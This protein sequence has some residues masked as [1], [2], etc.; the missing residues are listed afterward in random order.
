MKNGI[1]KRLLALFLAVLLLATSDTSL[2]QVLA[3]DKPVTEDVSKQEEQRSPVAENVG[4]ENDENKLP[5]AEAKSEEAKENIETNQAA[6]VA[7][8]P[9]NS[10]AN[11]EQLEGEEAAPATEEL[12]DN[13]FA[14]DVKVAEDVNA[15]NPTLTDSI[16]KEAGQAFLYNIGYNYSST[17][18]ATQV[19]TG[20]LAIKFP[21]N[22]IMP[23]ELFDE[24]GKSL[25]YAFGDYVENSY[26]NIKGNVLYV[27]MKPQSTG[28]ASN[29]N[30]IFDTL[31]YTTK[32]GTVIK[33]GSTVT[34]SNN[35]NT[36][37]LAIEPNFIYK[38]EGID[39]TSTVESKPQIEITAKDKW[40]IKKSA[41]DDS[42]RE[43]NGISI[44]NGKEEG[45][46]YLGK[47]KINLDPNYEKIDASGQRRLEN[48]SLV[49][50]IEED[51]LNNGR[52]VNV[53]NVTMNGKPMAEGDYEV[54]TDNGVVKAIKF[55]TYDKLTE[56]GTYSRAGEITRTEYQYE[57]EYEKEGYITDI[58]K[59][60][61]K[62]TL[63]DTADLSY[64][65]IGETTPITSTS[66]A[67]IVVGRYEN[68]VETNHV[69]LNKFIKYD[70]KEM[71]LSTGNAQTFGTGTIKFHLKNPNGT[72]ALDPNTTEAY[73]DLT[74]DSFGNL[75]TPELKIG[76]EYVLEEIVPEGSTVDKAPGKQGDTQTA[77]IHFTV[78]K[79]GETVVIKN[80]NGYSTTVTGTGD[81][82]AIKI[83]NNIKNISGVEFTKTG[84]D[85]NGAE[86]PLAGV[87]FVLRG[88]DGSEYHTTSA[89]DGKVR[90][91][92][93]VPSDSKNP[94]IT[95]NIYEVK[96]DNS[97]PGLEE[98]KEIPLVTM[99]PGGTTTNY[100]AYTPIYENLTVEGGIIKR[101]TWAGK[102]EFL[103]ISNK[104]FFKLIKTDENGNTI[105]SPAGSEG[106]FE[107]YGPL[108]GEDKSTY[109]NSDGSVKDDADEN[110]DNWS[111]TEVKY[112]SDGPSYKPTKALE[113]GIYIIKE[114]KAPFSYSINGKGLSEA[115]VVANTTTEVNLKNSRLQPVRFLKYGSYNEERIDGLEYFNGVKFD[116]YKAAKENPDVTNKND[117]E[118]LE[119]TTAAT[120]AKEED[121]QAV[122]SL[123]TD[124]FSLYL[125][126]GETYYY[127]ET[128]PS[129]DYK[130]KANEEFV[131]FTVEEADPVYTVEVENPSNAGKIEIQK[132]DNKTD[133]PLAGAKYTIYKSNAEGEK[134]DKVVEG[135]TTTADGKIL[136]NLLKAGEDYLIEETKAP[137]GYKLPSPAATKHIKLETNKTTSVT[138]KN[139]KFVTL[140]VIKVD[141][142][143]NALEGATFNYQLEGQKAEPMP[144]RGNEYTLDK[145]VLGEK[146]TLK[147]TAPEGYQGV[148]DFTVEI[149]KNDNSSED[150]LV[151]QVWNEDSQTQE[152]TVT[153]KKN[154]SITISKEHNYNSSEYGP[155]HNENGPATFALYEKDKDGKF[156]LAKDAKG[157]DLKGNTSKEG[158]ITLNNLVPGKT[159][160]IKEDKVPDGYKFES[161]EGAG[162]EKVEDDYY[163]FSATAATNLTVTAK[164]KSTESKVKIKKVDGST[165]N[166]LAKV[167]FTLQKL[168]ANNKWQD[169]K[170]AETAANGEINAE[171][172]GG[173]SEGKY[174]LVE[175][176]PDGYTTDVSDDRATLSKD[177]TKAY[178][179]FEIDSS[180]IGKEI[181]TFFDN[182]IKNIQKA[183]LKV[184]KV[185]LYKADNEEYSIPLTGATFVIYGAKTDGSIDEGNQIGKSIEMS[186]STEFT[187]QLPPGTYFLKESAAPKGYKINDPIKV[188][189]TAGENKE[190]T[191]NNLPDEKGIIRVDKYATSG[192]LITS[193][194]ANFEIYQKVSGS[195]S[196][197]IEYHDGDQTI[198]LEKVSKSQTSTN[199]EH[200]QDSNVVVTIGGHGYT[201]PLTKGEVYYF[202]ETKAPSGYEIIDQ[203]N[204]WTGPITVKEGLN[205]VPVN[206]APKPNEPG[207]GEV[208]YSM[209]K[210]A[211]F[212]TIAG[213]ELP[214]NGVKYFVYDT[215]ITKESETITSLPALA[216][217][218]LVASGSTQHTDLTGGDG[219]YVS[220]PLV[221]NRWYI[222]IEAN[223]GQYYNNSSDAPERVDVNN[224]DVSIGETKYE[225]Q[226]WA[227]IYVGE[228]SAYS[229]KEAEPYPIYPNEDNK[230]IDFHN[231]ATMGRFVLRKEVTGE[232]DATTGFNF[233]L[234]R[235]PKN[236]NE[237]QWIPIDDIKVKN[238]E[239][240]LSKELST[241]YE[242]KLE[243]QDLGKN[244]DYYFEESGHNT[245]V[246]TFTLENAKI[247]GFDQA[248]YKSYETKEEAQKHPILYTNL[249]KAELNIHKTGT[250]VNEKGEVTKKDL[251]NVTFEIYKDKDY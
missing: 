127:K 138:F 82:S 228:G 249:K 104:G 168:D 222:V 84:K 232:T 8:Q 165:N 106:K 7:A 231:D 70:G 202:K 85:A 145:I 107:V 212:T 143:G 191:V 66:Q 54:V 221:P 121:G 246:R 17:G 59:E 208:K 192:E 67:G 1:G 171:A 116:I 181:T 108:S 90:F 46:Y 5:T 122:S 36:T 237:D 219:I 42:A 234:S 156:T 12:G 139:D 55:K 144:N 152:V 179:D 91:N 27:N 83:V 227:P 39:F 164:N 153:N 174:R 3:T 41:V 132:V 155:Y 78:P 151:K 245:K 188:T 101:P 131:P 182:P 129:G 51:Y 73:E 130:F 2:Y 154:A 30:V 125:K 92:D 74:L 50:T 201:I 19:S 71:A 199:D 204:P 235:K 89:A 175:T 163:K 203:D 97:K 47:F 135:L 126:V 123:K 68:N 205:I 99:A 142:D 226:N 69:N 161:I 23:R 102:N 31:N 225:N 65:P 214:V 172:F 81:N 211:K 186:D 194:F 119:D 190:V 148:P 93:V 33:D 22:V 64:T 193:D 146:Y 166:A 95:Y 37:S 250:W 16:T 44:A 224:A 115:E 177:G 6:S 9:G 141:Q 160:Y 79:K 134:L 4:Q 216:D 112:D 14:I 150:T 11:T 244:G 159:Y 29:V 137:E 87:E 200:N 124:D 128:I 197:V 215:G 169:V 140:K 223:E 105:N 94:Q 187:R 178:Y 88:S 98:F 213:E 25:G 45:D 40:Q 239:T 167:S 206:N 57:I 28:A 238:L 49:D 35:E 251:S 18:G 118:L 195:G 53:K 241:K 114:T 136:S 80:E 158:K 180:N 43:E 198:Y 183:T 72:P 207:E 176:L 15:S 230:K 62:T 196:N 61:K 48:F 247:T 184:K 32:D 13:T 86:K 96:L 113:A 149:G 157:G 240:Y 26:I 162:L 242:Y 77:G 120:I 21:E 170:T 58:G 20:V 75:K 117:F 52:P 185:G 236:S 109:L 60:L 210:V 76:S 110:L 103:N 63:K 229:G 209:L 248:D 243:E 233:T 173:L 220:A 133:A 56:D 111:K 38:L 10:E 189:I 24:N 147:E 100:A 34:N 217:M 218:K